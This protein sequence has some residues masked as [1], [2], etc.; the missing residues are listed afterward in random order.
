MCFGFIRSGGCD[1]LKEKENGLN[2]ISY[3]RARQGAFFL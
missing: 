1:P 3:K 2:S